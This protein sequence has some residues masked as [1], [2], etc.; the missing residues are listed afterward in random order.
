MVSKE[1]LSKINKDI[2]NIRFGTRLY[3]VRSISGYTQSQFAKL[4]SLTFDRYQNLESGYTASDQSVFIRIVDRV[5]VLFGI[6]SSALIAEKIREEAFKDVVKTV[7]EH[8]STLPFESLSVK[9]LSP[10]IFE[11]VSE[12]DKRIIVSVRLGERVKRIRQNLNLNQ[13]QFSEALSITL[14]RLSSLETGSTLRNYAILIKILIIFQRVNVSMY[15]LI[16]ES[17]TQKQINTKIKAAR[18]KNGSKYQINVGK[19]VKL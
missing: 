14:D 10:G 15:D 6:D 3:F 5:K 2:Y 4:L 9:F 8:N 16:S 1:L 7:W 12:T 17:L 11:H 19:L 13:D 18:E